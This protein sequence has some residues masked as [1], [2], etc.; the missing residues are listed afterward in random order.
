MALSTLTG[1]SWAALRR[2]IPAA[3]CRGCRT[4]RLSR[5]CAP[6]LE[7]RAFHDSLICRN[8]ILL[9]V[10]IEGSAL[11]VQGNKSRTRRALDRVDLG[12]ASE[13][14]P[15]DLSSGERERLE[16]AAVAVAQPDL[17][18]LDERKAES[19]AWLAGYAAE[20]RGVLVA[21][22][23]PSFPADRR[24]APAKDALLGV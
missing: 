16:L 3:V 13:R 14:H 17:L 12:W 20:G 4:K 21:I 15:R 7:P 2:T 10:A 6:F 22:H 8:L 11:A 5:S 19:A 1:S 24:V 9:G 18:A 23:D